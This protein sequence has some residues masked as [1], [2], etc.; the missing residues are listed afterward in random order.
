MSHLSHLEPITAI[1][2][3]RLC[4]W[5]ED[6]FAYSFV[7]VRSRNFVFTVVKFSECG[8]E[9]LGNFFRCCR[10]RWVDF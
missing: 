7:F 8:E 2:S 5:G 1:G 6:G 9:G 3:G 4:G 10:Y